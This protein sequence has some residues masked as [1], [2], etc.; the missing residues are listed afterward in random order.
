MGIQLVAE[1]PDPVYSYQAGTDMAHID[2][3]HLTARDGSATVNAEGHGVA[4]IIVKG[5]TYV[6]ELQAL[7]QIDGMPQDL[8]DPGIQ[9]VTVRGM[10]R[11]HVR[12]SEI[13][14]TFTGTVVGSNLVKLYLTAA[15]TAAMTAHRGQWDAEIEWQ[16]PDIPNRVRKLC[17]GSWAALGEATR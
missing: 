2:Q 10:L 16:D 15:D 12:S 17:R 8:T 5:D 13:Q 1:H 7:D 3:I 9:P 6:L 11:K 14:A 4:P